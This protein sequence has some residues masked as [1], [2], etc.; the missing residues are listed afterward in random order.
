MRKPK[1][2]LRQGAG[3]AGGLEQKQSPLG[4]QTQKE[5][6]CGPEPGCWR[7]PEPSPALTLPEQAP[8]PAC[9][10]SGMDAT[11]PETK[12]VQ[13]LCSQASTD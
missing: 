1:V 13:R 9:E 6:A 11:W 12:N 7:P 2:K 5:T 10:Q 3:K 8:K 4:A